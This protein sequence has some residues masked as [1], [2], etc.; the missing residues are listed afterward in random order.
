MCQY[1]CEYTCSERPAIHR[2][3]LLSHPSTDSHFISKRGTAH[4]DNVS[5]LDLLKLREGLY[6]SYT[7]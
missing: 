4:G 7:V 6:T 5:F 2:A 3:F 1:K